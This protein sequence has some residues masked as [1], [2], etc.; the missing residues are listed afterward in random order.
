M[1][2]PVAGAFDIPGSGD[3]F[4]NNYFA[5]AQGAF[6][7]AVRAMIGAAAPSSTTISSGSITPSVAC[8]E[9][10]TEGAAASDDLTRI[11]Y[12]NLA[13]GSILLLWP[14]NASRVVTVKHTFTASYSGRIRL[15]SEFD[16][17]MDSASK[18]IML[19]RRGSVWYEI[20]RIG[21]ITAEHGSQLFT[22]NGTLVVPA[23]ITTIY[24]T[25]LGGGGGGGGGAGTNT[26]ATGTNGS[27]GTQGGTTSVQPY[28]TVPGGNGGV[29]GYGNG[30]GGYGATLG[31]IAGQNALSLIGGR[32]GQPGTTPL[33]LYGRGGAGGKG[34]DG[35]LTVAGGGGSSGGISTSLYMKYPV[36]VT[37]GE[38]ITV[39]I[40]AGGAGGA[41]GTGTQ[42][43]G[44]AGQSG[45]DGAVVIEW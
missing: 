32:G 3:T 8:N 20:M 25:A 24:V 27:A 41:G 45:A 9:V 30:L 1:S 15:Q 38:T 40:G 35:G 33:G 10:D 42:S 44:D 17:I 39:V 34:A 5:T 37:P 13:D 26:G 2:L 29:Q 22:A 28:L 12:D 21:G 14:A 11:N 16:H 7:E 43:N 19:Q 6:L 23:G 36:T 18:C 4:T 31:M